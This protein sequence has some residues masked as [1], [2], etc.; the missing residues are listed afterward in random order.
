MSALMCAAN[1]KLSSDR[2]PAKK[3]NL[4]TKQSSIQKPSAQRRL[5]NVEYCTMGGQKS[6]LSCRGVSKA[7][8]VRQGVTLGLVLAPKTFKACSRPQIDSDISLPSPPPRPLPPLPCHPVWGFPSKSS[9]R[10]RKGE[11]R[12]PVPQSLSRTFR[13]RL[14]A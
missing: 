9:Q 14:P 2:V 5:A 11:Q 8:I 4:K 13:R 1:L 7:H 10:C 6:A 12:G 3:Q